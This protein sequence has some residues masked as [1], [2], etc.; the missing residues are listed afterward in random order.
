MLSTCQRRALAATSAELPALLAEEPGVLIEH[1]GVPLA[2]AL[3]ARTTPETA[4]LRAL[5]LD[6][7]LPLAQTL[8]ALLPPLRERL[9]AAMVRTLFFGGDEHGDTWLRSAL[10]TRGATSATEVVG[11]EN[12]RLI[13]P[14]PGDQSV[15][16]R[17]AA[18]A[19]LPALIALDQAAF[20]G[21]WHKDRRA[22][23]PALAD[24]PHFLVA[25]REQRLIGY[26]F[27]S[28]HFGGRMVHLVRIAVAPEE[29]GRGVGV[30]L[31]GEVVAYARAR[32]ADVLTLNTQLDNHAARR[33]YEWFGFRRTGDRQ[34]IVRIEL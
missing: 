28:V 8:D 15:T 3:T 21:Q 17:A 22:L 14:G 1:A 27:V 12:I 7:A 31:L 18:A 4:W 25:E 10:L 24:S 6:D 16:V 20:E 23:A 11:Y 9:R 5:A 30:R 32:R 29:Q 13:T 19:D 33:L 26:T 34:T 2:F